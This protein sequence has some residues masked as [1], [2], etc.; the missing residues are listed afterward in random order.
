MYKNPLLNIAI[1]ILERRQWDS[2]SRS[3]PPL[4]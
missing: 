1:T 4:C 3:W 2:C